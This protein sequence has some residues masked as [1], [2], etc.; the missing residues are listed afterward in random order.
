[1]VEFAPVLP[2]EL[3]PIFD[4][5]KYHLVQAHMIKHNRRIREWFAY[6]VGRGHVVI[7]DNG[8]FE[9]GEPDITSLFWVARAIRP[10]IIVCP[11]MYCDAL[12]TFSLFTQYLDVCARHAQGVMMVPHGDCTDQWVECAARMLRYVECVKPATKMYLGVP[13]V[14]DSYSPNGR[15]AA[16]VALQ[17][18]GYIVTPSATHLLGVWNYL[19]ELAPLVAVYPDLMGLDTTLPVARALAPA[20]EDTGKCKLNHEH[21]KLT[22][23]Q[24]EWSQRQRIKS[25]I[26]QVRLMLDQWCRAAIAPAVLTEISL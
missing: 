19:V 22:E 11:D 23:D 26:L 21:W 25:N 1:M 10:T 3:Y 13:K 24:I 15:L 8:A 17:R 2:P 7:L 6:R 12:R 9:L 16:L 14:L 20:G 5:G 18:A 4:T